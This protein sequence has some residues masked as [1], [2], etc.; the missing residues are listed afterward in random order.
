MSQAPFDYILQS[1]EALKSEERRAEQYLF[2]K[3]HKDAFLETAEKN[4]ID[5]KAEEMILIKDNGLYSWLASRNEEA[6]SNMY[7]L[8]KRRPD[9]SFPLIEKGM[10]THFIK[11]GKEIVVNYILNAK[12][13]PVQ[14]IDDIVKLK[15][16]CNLIVDVIFTKQEQR[17]SKMRE[18]V[19][20]EIL[21]V[22]SAPNGKFIEFLAA[23]NLETYTNNK[24]KKCYTA[25][26]EE[27]IFNNIILV[28]ESLSA[29]DSY[30]LELLR[31]MFK[32]LLE[33]YT[34]KAP[35]V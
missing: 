27:E 25:Q 22:E 12:K 7:K 1:L 28:F 21:K 2:E 32:R 26:G 10:K 11:T 16:F 14:Y 6:L 30:L 34:S 24:I 29:R 20:K 31:G 13:D 5:V 35:R 18:E 3:K 9:I 33:Y 8:Y 15:Q 23:K 4:L 17:F 19:F